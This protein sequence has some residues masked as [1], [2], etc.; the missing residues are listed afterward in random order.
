LQA[1]YCLSHTSSS[2]CS[3]Y[4]RDGVLQTICLGWPQTT[5][6]LISASQALRIIGVSHQRLALRDIY[7]PMFAEELFTMTKRRKG[8]NCPFTGKWINKI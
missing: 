7:R 4:F 8:F 6:L 5:I 2:F 1:L 3:G